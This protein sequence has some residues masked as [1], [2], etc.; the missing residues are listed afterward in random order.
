MDGMT[1]QPA[2]ALLNRRAHEL[3]C[4]ARA[5]EAGKRAAVT[6][7]ASLRRMADLLRD[8]AQILA[9]GFRGF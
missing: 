9:P 2:A 8:A 1:Y 7:P 4:E 3:E 6:A 5:V